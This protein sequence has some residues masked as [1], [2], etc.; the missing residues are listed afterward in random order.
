M[1][2]SWWATERALLDGFWRLTVPHR[3]LHRRLLHL[4]YRLRWTPF[5]LVVAVVVV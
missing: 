5:L 3:P 1:L 2:L 4:R